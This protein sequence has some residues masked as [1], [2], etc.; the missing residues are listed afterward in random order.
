MSELCD[1][2]KAT[3]RAWAEATDSLP[4]RHVEA[5]KSLE[6][7]ADVLAKLEAACGGLIDGGS[8]TL[9]GGRG[10]GKTQ[11]AV[12]LAAWWIDLRAKDGR[13][14]SVRYARMFDLLHTV[15]HAAYDER[16]RGP[17][18]SWASVGLLI[19]DEINEQRLT[20]DDALWFVTLFDR[21]YAAMRPT[22]LIGNTMPSEMPKVVGPSVWSR[23]Q[24]T[25]RLLV[26]DWPS[27]REA[28]P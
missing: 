2:Q 18:D 3:R 6:W 22:I 25:G 11:A 17:L 12:Q 1:T 5:M 24:E 26:C 23:L 4:K 8:L 16:L 9:L 7:S 10:T 14:T 15:K 19:I 28:K 27:F 13:S 20:N 21:R